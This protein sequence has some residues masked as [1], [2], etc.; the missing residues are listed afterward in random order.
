MTSGCGMR[1][2]AAATLWVLIVAA[3]VDVTAQSAG[4]PTLRDAQARATEFLAHGPEAENADRRARLS[5][6]LPVRATLD[7]AV[8]RVLD[9]RS[10][11][12]VTDDLDESGL[13]LESTFRDTGRTELDVWRDAR[14]RLEWDL[15]SLVHDDE[16]RDRARDAQQA[17]ELVQEVQAGVAESWWRWR[18][19]ESECLSGDADA[20]VE[21]ERW[22]GELDAWTDGWFSEAMF[23][24]N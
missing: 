4:L 21:R 22:V 16:V 24:A 20:C 11:S 3:A 13:L 8:R 7:L 23:G 10:E 1:L 5:H 17:R 18:L 6:L 12:Q 9:T 15:R 19:S 2:V 14:I